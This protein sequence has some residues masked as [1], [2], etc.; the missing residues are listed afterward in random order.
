VRAESA[1]LTGRV[2]EYLN[3]TVDTLRELASGVKEPEPKKVLDKLIEGLAMWAQQ[4]RGKAFGATDIA[5]NYADLQRRYMSVCKRS[6]DT[7]KILT[8]HTDEVYTRRKAKAEEFGL[9]ANTDFS[10]VPKV[11][12]KLLAAARQPGCKFN[13]ED[14]QQF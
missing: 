2:D 7:R 14:L 8:S 1:R 10:N 5:L 4:N 13:M 6:D 11:I 12:A 3:N 9:D